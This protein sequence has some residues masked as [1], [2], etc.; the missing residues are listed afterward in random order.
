MKP[1]YV[2]VEQTSKEWGLWRADGLGASDAPVIMFD[3]MDG[4]PFKL[5]EQKIGVRKQKADN[6]FMARGRKI[7]SEARNAYSKQTGNLAPAACYEH[8]AFRHLRCSTDGAYPLE[9]PEL[10]VELKCPDYKDTHLVAKDG[11]V[12]QQYFAQV[13]HTLMVTGA[14]QCDFGSYWHGDLAIVKALPDRGYIEDRLLPAEQTFWRMVLDG[15][16]VT[17]EGEVD[18]SADEDWQHFAARYLEVEGLFVHYKNLLAEMEGELAQL[19]G[20]RLRSFGCGVECR[21]NHTVR[22]AESKP[23]GPVDSWS[24]AV[25]SI[26]DKRVD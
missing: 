19:N 20:Q 12:P 6:K 7:E 22:K 18:M 8:P 17:P 2:N 10:V 1:I 16:W 21:W 5:F 9:Q 25:R 13:Q 14:K 3:S 11:K 23:R 4:S 24:V 15:R 26:P